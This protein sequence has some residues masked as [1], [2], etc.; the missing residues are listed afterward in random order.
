MTASTNKVNVSVIM[1]PPTTKFTQR[2]LERPYRATIG[3]D[4]KVYEAYILASSTEAMRLY[5]RIN[6]FVNI[7]NA[8]GIANT[9]R[10]SIR[11]PP[12]ARFIS[13]MFISRLARNI[14]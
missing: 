10:P 11:A 8:I 3:Y 4:I 7:P 13:C 6:I 1:V 2:N 9:A 14:I 5:S 12:L